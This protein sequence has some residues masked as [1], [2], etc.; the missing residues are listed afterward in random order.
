MSA[1]HL[2]NSVLLGPYLSV[3]ISAYPSHIASVSTPNDTR[4]C[5]GWTVLYTRVWER[6]NYNPGQTSLGQYCEYFFYV[7]LLLLK[8]DSI[9]IYK[10][11]QRKGK[12][13]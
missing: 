5:L 12:V 3:S 6:S 2:E 4:T 8:K 13:F 7:S 11:G 10:D 9:P 1:T